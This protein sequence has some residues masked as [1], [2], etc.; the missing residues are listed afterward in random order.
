MKLKD[1]L[2]KWGMTSLSIK[3]GFLEM[4]WEPKDPDRKAAPSAQRKFNTEQM[5]WLSLVREQLIINLT[6]D[7]DDF[8]NTPLLQGP[9]AP[10]VW[11]IILADDLGQRN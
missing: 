4:E 8:D 6:I 10:F 3:A 11:Q 2:E 5:Q 9:L 7:E 1:W